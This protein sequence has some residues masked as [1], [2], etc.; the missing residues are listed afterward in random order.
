MTYRLGVDLGT[1]FTAAAVANG[2]APSMLGLG[3]RA[4]QVPSVLYIPAE[5][6]VV[7]GEAAERR[8]LT[9]PS[10][11]VREFKRRIGDHVPILVA[12]VPYSPQ[13]LTARLL[14]W[15]VRVASEQ[16]GGP[17]ERVILTYPANWGPF[18]RELLKQ[19]IELADVGEVDTC[20]EPEAAA[21]QY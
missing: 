5:G 11:V 4:L 8:G 16:M 17:P 18:K 13:A 2:G 10:R 1:T 6:D 7:V 21:V 20:S 19:V 14:Q 15:V 3:N 9:D 12:G